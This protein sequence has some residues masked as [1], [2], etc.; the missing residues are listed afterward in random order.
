MYESEVI[1]RRNDCESE[2]MRK[3]LKSREK[4]NTEKKDEDGEIAFG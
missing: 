4:I 2:I 3:L 1:A